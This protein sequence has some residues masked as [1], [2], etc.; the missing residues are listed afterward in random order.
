M[1]VASPMP[2]FAPVTTTDLSACAPGFPDVGMPLPSAAA[3]CGSAISARVVGRMCPRGTGSGGTL[4]SVKVSS[5]LHA[6][7]PGTPVGPAPGSATDAA[8]PAAAAGTPV[9]VL[10]RRLDPDL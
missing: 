1:A 4:Q 8:E 3:S 9:R 5:A 10:L 2:L 6:A 7:E